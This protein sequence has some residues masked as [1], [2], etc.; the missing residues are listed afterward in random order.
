MLE[1]GRAVVTLPARL[2]GGRWT[3]GYYHAL[4]IKESTLRLLI[5]ESEEGY[6]ELATALGTN[7][8]LRT[9]VEGEIQRVIPKLFGRWEAVEEWQRILLDV[10]PITPCAIFEQEEKREEL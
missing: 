4:G 3:R 7:A 2:L 1:L 8:T 5:A 10:S 6:I 9:E